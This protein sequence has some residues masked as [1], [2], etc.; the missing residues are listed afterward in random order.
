MTRVNA[1][2]GNNSPPFCVGW[3]RLPLC[4]LISD[5][6]HFGSHYPLLV[7]KRQQAG[8]QITTNLKL[9]FEKSSPVGRS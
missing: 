5:N 9:Y 8:H 3:F 4:A 6:G 2:R 7:L 1:L